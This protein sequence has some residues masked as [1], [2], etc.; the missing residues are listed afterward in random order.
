MP[1]FSPVCSVPV[2]SL[3]GGVVVVV[4]CLEAT[5]YVY[6]LYNGTVT[7]FDRLGGTV[8]VAD[9]MAGAFSVCPA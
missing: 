1:C 2:C 6:D 3:Q 9:G 5:V 7:A 8:G 4:L